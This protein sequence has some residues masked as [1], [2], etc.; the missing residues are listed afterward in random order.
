MSDRTWIAWPERD[1][2]P[3]HLALLYDDEAWADLMADPDDAAKTR[4]ILDAAA[5]ARDVPH[6]SYSSTS[7]HQ[8]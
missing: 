1:D 4:A 8:K 2:D 5:R 3:G 7:N 6:G